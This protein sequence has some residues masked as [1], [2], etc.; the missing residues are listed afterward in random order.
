MNHGKG[1]IGRQYQPD[2]ASQHLDAILGSG[3]LAQSVPV[4]RKP[5]FHHT[6]HDLAGGRES[7]WNCGDGNRSMAA[8]AT[9]CQGG[10]GGGEVPE[11]WVGLTAFGSELH[12]T[13]FCFTGHNTTEHKTHRAPQRHNHINTQPIHE[14]NST[15]GLFSTLGCDFLPQLD[16]DG[17]ARR[18]DEQPGWDWTGLD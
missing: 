4:L 17:S 2:S 6:M 18:C 1:K 11:A 3:V 9:F 15:G 10:Q 7:A 14:R 16:K 12:P 13:Q 5:Y 8:T